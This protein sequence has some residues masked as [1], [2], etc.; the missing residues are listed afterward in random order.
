MYRQLSPC[1]VSRVATQLLFIRLDYVKYFLKELVG[2]FPPP[3]SAVGPLH[4]LYTVR[5]RIFRKAL[6]FKH[7]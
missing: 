2:S 7:W 4:S 5:F 1:K 3:P 6:V